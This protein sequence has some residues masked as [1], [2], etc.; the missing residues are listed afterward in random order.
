MPTETSAAGGAA[1]DAEAMRLIAA[2]D[3]ARA[4]EKAV[5]QAAH[6]DYCRA[7]QALVQHEEQARGK[8]G[9]Q[10]RTARHLD[11]TAQNVGVMV[12]KVGT[13]PRRGSSEG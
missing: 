8:R 5:Q 2:V 13:T 7:I 12:A 3:A 6:L 4:R 1:V 9:A 10:A 11:M